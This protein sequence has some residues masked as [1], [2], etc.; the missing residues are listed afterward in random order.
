[1]VFS[2]FSGGFKP[3]FYFWELVVYARKIA[4]ICTVVFMAANPQLQTLSTIGVVVVA[5]VL[6]SHY[7][8]FAN[9]I[10]NRFETVSLIASAV[11]LFS[12]QYILLE[13]QDSADAVKTLMTWV[14][15]LSNLSFFVVFFYWFTTQYRA[16][17]KLKSLS[18]VRHSPSQAFS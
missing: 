13:L 1:M 5:L 3:D 14:F 7:K 8:P 9:Q 10:N 2:S 12:G 17:K 15:A 4:L 11:C 6:Q 18:Q 16:F